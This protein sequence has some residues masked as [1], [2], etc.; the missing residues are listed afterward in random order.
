MIKYNLN[1][2][3]NT[4]ILYEIREEDK[5]KSCIYLIAIYYRK[6]WRLTYGWCFNFQKHM[7]LLNKKLHLHCE[8]LFTNKYY[9]P[10][11][12]PLI[13]LWT[14]S[15]DTIIDFEYKFPTIIKE[16]NLSCSNKLKNNLKFDYNVYDKFL[17]YGIDH[18]VHNTWESDIYVFN[19][20]NQL[21]FKNFIINR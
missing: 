5:N 14:N 11:I 13:I 10:K 9:I 1:S 4:A 8:E 6:K 20:S 17:Q 2:V 15:I 19:D 12:I 7:K 3:I 21:M 16:N 18:D